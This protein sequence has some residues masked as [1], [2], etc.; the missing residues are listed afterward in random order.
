MRMGIK[1]N[2]FF[3]EKLLGFS[4]R[5]INRADLYGT[6]RRIAFDSQERECATALMSK[7]GRH[8][9]GA[10]GLAGLYLDANGDVVDVK[11]LAASDKT[12]D[13]KEVAP[14]A[15]GDSPELSGPVPTA[16]LL[17]CMVTAVYRVD[18]F[19]LVSPLAAALADGEIYQLPFRPRASS[20]GG[21]AF[22]LANEHGVFMVTVQPAR[23][24]F[25]G[26]DAPVAIE[27]DSPD[28][29]SDLDFEDWRGER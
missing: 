11:D 26:Q 28:E 13:Q 8:L 4:L 21:T 3:H 16:A 9:F 25:I 20:H 18:D 10:G 24:E 7:D 23:F 19:D 2:V 6:H 29:T 27:E 22:L 17:D 5:K 14:P 1:V 15:D 12:D